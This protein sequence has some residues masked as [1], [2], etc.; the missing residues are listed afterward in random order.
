MNANTTPDIPYDHWSPLTVAEVVTLFDD[1]PFTWGLAGGYAIE[2]Y[3]GQSIRQ[4]DDIDI[5]VFREDQLALQ[6]WLDGWQLYAADPPGTLR[7][8]NADEVLPVG[9]HD[10]WGHRAGSNAWELQIML[11]ET[12][13]DEWVSRRSPLVRGHRHDLITTYGGIPCIRVEV[14]L[15][16]KAKGL[17]SKDELDFQACLPLLDTPSREWLKNSLTLLYP[18]RHPWIDALDDWQIK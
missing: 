8:W 5:L 9:I 4:H 17:R 14:Q 11:V 6:H 15:T 12:E 1:A 13:G 16:Y 7:L 3:L 10:I 18:Q 2:Q